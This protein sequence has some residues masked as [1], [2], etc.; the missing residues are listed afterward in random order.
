MYRIDD[1]KIELKYKR[2]GLLDY[3]FYETVGD[4]FRIGLY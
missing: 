3:Y 1:Y 4:G 2:I